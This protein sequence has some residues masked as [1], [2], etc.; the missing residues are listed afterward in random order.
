VNSIFCGSGINLRTQ[1]EMCSRYSAYPMVADSLYRNTEGVERVIF[2]ADFN[3]KTGI[4]PHPHWTPSW[5]DV[6]LA[7]SIILSYAKLN[8]KCY[9]KEENKYK[10]QYVGTNQGIIEVYLR[11]TGD[12]LPT[13]NLK[14]FIDEINDGGCGIIYVRIDL[15]NKELIEMQ[16]N[17][18]A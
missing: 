11:N 16:M 1:N 15:R 13:C 17:G 3:F 2:P 7:D 12:F 9:C 6:K 5:T 4:N 10:R 14:K 18:E 8:M